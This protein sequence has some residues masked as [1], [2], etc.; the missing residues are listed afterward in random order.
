VSRN[1]DGPSDGRSKTN[2]SGVPQK[3][4]P[5]N[6][7]HGNGGQTAGRR[8][9]NV[10]GAFPL[11]LIGSVLLVYAG[12]LVGEGLSSSGTHLPLWGLVVGV[13]AVILGAGIYS[14]FLEPVAPPRSDRNRE[15]V[16]VPRAEYEALRSSRRANEG[17]AS[18]RREP[19]WWEGPPDHPT[20]PP[21]RHAAPEVPRGRVSP[22]PVRSTSAVPPPRLTPP[23]PSMST[24]GTAGTA[25]APGLL[26]RAPSPTGPAPKTAQRGF[27]K[28]FMDS[29]TELEALANR[30]LKS[31]PQR[32]GRAAPGEPLSC[33]DCKRGLSN[34][35]SPSRCSD[36]RSALCVDCALS[37][38]MEDGDLR[39]VACRVRRP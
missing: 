20:L 17:P 25:A 34:D 15:W 19:P 21:P 30:Q 35:P 10:E 2:D 37:S 13:G 22:A 18:E 16:T 31:S 14:T 38:Q 29:L 12:V 5:S 8:R 6:L 4:P 9:L 28:E 32:L 3:D 26:T 36:C 33:A 7:L 11:L 39:C 23:A 27:P 1:S 24:G